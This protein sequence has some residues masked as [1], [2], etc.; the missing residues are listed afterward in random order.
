MK[1][2]KGGCISVEITNE[3]NGWHLHS[4]WLVDAR[5]IDAGEL[6]IAWGKQVGQEFGIVKV[7]DAREKSYAQEVAKYVVKGAEMA[8]WQPEHMLEFVLAVK[9]CRFFFTF[10][11]LSKERARIK[12]TLEAQKPPM[13]PCACGCEKWVFETEERALLNQLRREARNTRRK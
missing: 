11:T 8:K 10:G 1:Q 7:M 2:V 6:A 3:G 12:A 5:W 4:H 9:G 13:A